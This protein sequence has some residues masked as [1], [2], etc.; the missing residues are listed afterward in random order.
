ML[1]LDAATF[2]PATSFLM[3]RPLHPQP[4]FRCPR[5]LHPHVLRD[6]KK[7]MVV[8]QLYQC[9][10]QTVNVGDA[11]T[12]CCSLCHTDTI[13]FVFALGGHVVVPIGHSAHV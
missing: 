2:A 7:Q 5:P 9:K 1:V 12:P 11:R 3:P 4:R 10:S 8:S 13:Q 6:K